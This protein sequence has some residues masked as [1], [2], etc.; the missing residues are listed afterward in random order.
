VIVNLRQHKQR[1]VSQLDRA[2][3]SKMDSAMAQL[4]QAAGR[5]ADAMKRVSSALIVCSIEIGEQLERLQPEWHRS[6]MRAAEIAYCAMARYASN[7]Q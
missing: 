6:R 4:A 5:A 7:I 2:M 1:R 3:I